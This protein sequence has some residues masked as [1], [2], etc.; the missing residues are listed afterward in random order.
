VFYDE[1]HFAAHA[2]TAACYEVLQKWDFGF[3]HQV[4]TYTRRHNEAASSFARRVNSYFVGKL[5]ILQRYGPVYLDRLEYEECLRR[6]L[7]YYY[8]FLG[9]SVLRKKDR[10]FWDY[11]KNAL[12]SLGHSLS[13]AKLFTILIS[14][15]AGVLL[16]PLKAVYKIL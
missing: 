10:Q 2:D 11:H 9:K 4:L 15:I 13:T 12:E 6:Y 3:V 7:K 8:R 1:V 16:N 5:A 14:I